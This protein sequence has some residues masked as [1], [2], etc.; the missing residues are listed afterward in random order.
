MLNKFIYAAILPFCFIPK[1]GAQESKALECES[2]LHTMRVGVRHIENKGVGYN[3]GYSTLEAFFAPYAL[4]VTPFLDLRGHVFD[5]GKF[6][7]NAGIG[8]RGVTGNRIYGVN[9]Y[10]DYRNTSRQHYNQVSLGL[11]S[12]GIRRDFRLNG[13]L[14]VGAKI[15]SAYDRQSVTTYAFDSFE[16]HNALI[17]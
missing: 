10:Y 2:A 14:P 13:Y 5:D 3:T 15:S 16:G 1:I 9:T 7:A 12:L 17:K 4:S 11:E 8:I 6:A